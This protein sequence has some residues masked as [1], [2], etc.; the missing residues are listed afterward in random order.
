MK[1]NV[2]LWRTTSSQVPKQSINLPL[3]CGCVSTKSLR[4][5]NDIIVN[6]LRHTNNNYASIVFI[7]EIF[8]ENSSLRIGIVTANS[9]Q[10]VDVVRDQLLGRDFN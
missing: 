8:R 3:A 9:M 10:Y 6:S 1:T 4:N 7:H 2:F 5:R